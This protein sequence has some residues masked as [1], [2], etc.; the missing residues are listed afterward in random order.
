MS[1]DHLFEICYSQKTPSATTLPIT[2]SDTGKHHRDEDDENWNIKTRYKR[3]EKNKLDFPVSTV[4]LVSVLYSF[5]PLKYS[6]VFTSSR[7]GYT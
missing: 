7:C 3:S 1:G 2:S 5:D 6:I 4:R